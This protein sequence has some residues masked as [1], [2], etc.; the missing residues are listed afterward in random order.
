MASKCLGVERH[1]IEAQMQSCG[2]NDQV[3]D[4]DGNAF[5]RL[6]TL[7]APGQLSNLQG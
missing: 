2:S 7:D 6:F 1:H 5:R 4:S 3:L